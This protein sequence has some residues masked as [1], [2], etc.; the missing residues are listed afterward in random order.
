MTAI[1]SRFRTV[2]L[3]LSFLY[4]SQTRRSGY[5][6]FRRAV[7]EMPGL[8]TLYRE[9]E[10]G[11]CDT[12]NIGARIALHTADILGSAHTGVLPRYLAWVLAGVLLLALA[13]VG[14]LS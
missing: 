4:P 1:L 11:R 14:G 9:A 8:K 6:G 3:S 7:T 13:M 2:A 10:A 12:Y 5:S